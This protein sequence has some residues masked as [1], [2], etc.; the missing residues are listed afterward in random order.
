MQEC[1][2]AI[3]KALLQETKSREDITDECRNKRVTLSLNSI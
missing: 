2:E 1:V 3:K